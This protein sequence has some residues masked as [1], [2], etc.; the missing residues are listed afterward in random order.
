MDQMYAGEPTRLVLWDFSGADITPIDFPGVQEIAKLAV[1]YGR[2]RPG[3]KTAIVTSQ[4]VA[5]GISR[6]YESLIQGTVAPLQVYV[7]WTLAEALNFLG[8]EELPGH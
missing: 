1:K 8:I 6:V 5:F 7:C 4:Q 3:G 2:Q